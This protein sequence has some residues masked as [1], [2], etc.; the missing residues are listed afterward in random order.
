MKTG[1][2]QR[3]R[4]F[5]H[6]R[7]IPA[8]LIA[9]A[10]CGSTLLASCNL[11]GKAKTEGNG[12]DGVT[13]ASVD[14]EKMQAALAARLV[15][16]TDSTSSFPRQFRHY[17]A[18]YSFYTQ[19]GRLPLWTAN[20]NATKD[21]DTLLACIDHAGEHGFEPDHFGAARLHRLKEQ[22]LNAAA[23]GRVEYDSLAMLELRLSDAAVSYAS[24]LQDGLLDPTKVFSSKYELP[25]RPRANSGEILRAADI[26]AFLRG[27]QPAEPRYLAL[28]KAL[29]TVRALAKTGAITP[30]PFPGKKI[31]PGA[32]SPQ[33]GAI[34]RR[35]K[36]L[37][38]LRTSAGQMQ[39][40]SSFSSRY[41]ASGFTKY[42]SLLVKTV[43]EFQRSHGLLDDGVLGDRTFAALNLTHEERALR[44]SLTLER[45]RWLHYPG[46]GTYVRVNIP[47]FYLYGVENGTATMRM[48]VCTGMRWR[49][50]RIKGQPP[51]NYQT[52]IV[53][54][55]ISHMVLNPT[56]SVPPSIAVRETYHEAKKDS[57]YLRRHNY[58]V[59]LNNEVVPS[60]SI[61]WKDYNPD[62]L[63]FRFIQ[64]PGQGNALGRI[65]FMF[66]N[67]YD[68]YL[69]DTPKRAPFKY[70]TRSV[71]HGCIR[72][73]EPMRMV[74]FLLKG[75]TKWDR[76][77]TDE[78]LAATRTTK[79]IPLENRIPVYVDYNTVWVDDRGV[80]QFR[81]DIYGKDAELKR[82][83]L[84]AK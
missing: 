47:E 42:D 81:E 7:F 45:A 29:A 73:E 51:I 1:E 27:I 71:S 26:A 75:A 20:L 70:A 50:M 22:V 83:F 55:T 65:K 77:K 74:D 30:I 79:W 40:E 56:W 25:L 66:N 60:T 43:A 23:A 53:S 67:P 59:L 12:R 21:M 61:K 39:P 3:A 36:Y 52:P 24:H 69:H 46:V 76:A 14:A 18:V 62:K 38:Q 28:Q 6:L 72:I 19:R 31:E 49:S 32:F 34:E 5:G 58:K 78:Y 8:I 80:I 13:L 2:E 63:P 15:A 57:T 82:A 35:I 68:I 44:V 54:G 16:P 41:D 33:L 4:I 11:T 9:T 64:D 17:D 10:L 37:S 48:K 84:A